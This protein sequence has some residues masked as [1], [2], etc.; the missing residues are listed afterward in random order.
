MMKKMAAVFLASF[1]ALAVIGCGGD[2]KKQVDPSPGEVTTA[3][4]PQEV[5]PEKEEDPAGADTGEAPVIQEE[6]PDEADAEAGLSAAAGD[7]LEGLE[8][9]SALIGTEGLAQYADQAVAVSGVKS[10][11]IEDAGG[12]LLRL[13]YAADG[14]GAPGDDLYFSVEKDGR[15]QTCMVEAAQYGAGTELYQ[16]IEALEEDAVLDLV[17]TPV[18]QEDTVLHVTGVVLH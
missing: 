12:D 1:L 4:E 11:D 16:I 18:G 6:I 2:A 15:T 3:E 14:N 8:D 7:S 13:L 17:G 10:V 5:T 9:V